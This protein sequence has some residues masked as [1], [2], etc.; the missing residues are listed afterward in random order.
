[1][2]DHQAVDDEVQTLLSQ[3]YHQPVHSVA[4]ADGIAVVSDKQNAMLMSLW[5][6]T[7]DDRV[8]HCLTDAV[9][10]VCRR[11]RGGLPVWPDGPAV[12]AE[13]WRLIDRLM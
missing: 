12:T 6:V 1:M 8:G 5:A 9:T 2:K 11:R 13:D 7:A 4:D 3:H 10:R